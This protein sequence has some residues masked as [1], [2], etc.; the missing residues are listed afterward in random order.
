MRHANALLLLHL[1]LGPLQRFH[2]ACASADTGGS[3]VSMTVGPRDFLQNLPQFYLD[4]F[5]N[6]GYI[7]HN[8][9]PSKYMLLSIS[10][11]RSI[12]LI[13]YFSFWA[14]LDTCAF[15]ST[16]FLL[17]GSGS[18]NIRKTNLNFIISSKPSKPRV[19]NILV[20]CSVLFL[21]YNPCKPSN[22]AACVV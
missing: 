13:P 12:F 10:F 17:W 8:D 5:L 22:N 15:C 9:Y 14:L 20:C 6:V 21:M 7:T 11:M 2:D 19:Y 1:I 4:R 16:G 18:L 3:N